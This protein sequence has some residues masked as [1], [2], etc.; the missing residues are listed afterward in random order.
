MDVDLRVEI[1]RVLEVEEAREDGRLVE[2]R[3]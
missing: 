1:R 2:E 3:S